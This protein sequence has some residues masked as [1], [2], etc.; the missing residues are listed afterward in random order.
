MD[1]RSE[2]WPACSQD[3]DRNSEGG[4][5]VQASFCCYDHAH[6]RFYLSIPYGRS[7]EA[8]LD[9]KARLF[10]TFD[11]HPVGGLAA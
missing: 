9:G 1:E 2:E 5:K 11:L 4:L 8:W 10:D 7:A 6:Y 3:I